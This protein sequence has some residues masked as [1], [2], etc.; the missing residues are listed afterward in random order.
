MNLYRPKFVVPK[1]PIFLTK[2]METYRV[3]EQLHKERDVILADEIQTGL[4]IFKYL[5]VEQVFDTLTTV[6]YILQQSNA[7]YRVLT[8]S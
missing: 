3:V 2:K 8:S 1:H 5:Q 6:L 4:A 7:S